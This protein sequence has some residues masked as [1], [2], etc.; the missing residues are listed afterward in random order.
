MAAG[1][2]GTIVQVIGTVVDIEL[3]PDSLPGVYNAGEIDKNGTTM[4]AEVQQHLGNN[5]VRALTLADTDGLRRGA[6]AVD[7]GAPITVPVGPATLGRLFDVLGTAL[8]NMGPVDAA[9]HWPIHRP[10][11]NFEEQ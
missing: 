5:W 2:K 8:D 1:A 4:I 11:P 3:P 6:A 10:P 9:D 7:T